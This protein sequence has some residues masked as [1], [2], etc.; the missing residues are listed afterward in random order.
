MTNQPQNPGGNSPFA[1]I[2]MTDPTSAQPVADIRLLRMVGL[3]SWEGRSNGLPE[4][5]YDFI[6][7]DGR[8]SQQQ[9]TK[10]IEE[11]L[12]VYVRIGGMPVQREQGKPID[13]NATIA[14]QVLVPWP[15]IVRVH[16]QLWPIPGPSI[17]LPDEDGTERYPN[18]KPALPC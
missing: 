13:P 7:Y 15:W 1:V 18:G 10:L 2:P 6:S 4:E 3:I 17:A 9:V 8:L 12:A 16:P 14:D 11:K 5:I